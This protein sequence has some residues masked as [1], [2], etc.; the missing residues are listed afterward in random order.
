MKR[1]E[2]DKLTKALESAGWEL[3]EVQEESSRRSQIMGTVITQ[4]SPQDGL[5]LR[6]K[7]F[8]AI[9]NANR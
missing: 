9:S 8:V 4:D 7:G 5:T 2:F 1:Q 6:V 3:I